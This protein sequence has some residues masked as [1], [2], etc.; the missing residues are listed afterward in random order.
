MSSL[1]LSFAT[2]FP[3]ARC[4]PWQKFIFIYLI[5][6]TGSMNIK[7]VYVTMLHVEVLKEG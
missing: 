1:N 3:P 4:E 5:R 6:Y 2:L 7:H